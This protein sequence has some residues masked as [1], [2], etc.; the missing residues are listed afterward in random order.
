MPGAG[1]IFWRIVS[2]LFMAVGILGIIKKV[3]R[4][5]SIR[6]MH[7]TIGRLVEYNVGPERDEDDFDLF[8]PVY[9]YKWEGKKRLFY[10]KAGVLGYQCHTRGKRVHIIIDPQTKKVTCLEDKKSYDSKLLIF[11]VIGVFALVLT[12]MIETGMLSWEKIRFF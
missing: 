6:G 5:K 9:E 3:K 10:S 12:L 2:I 4:L 1:L 8:Y 7:K 11:G